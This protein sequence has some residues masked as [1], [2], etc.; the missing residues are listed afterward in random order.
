[1][2][3]AALAALVVV[4]TGCSLDLERLRR[5]S[6]ASTDASADA[7]PADSGTADAAPTDGSRPDSGCAVCTTRTRWN[8][9]LPGV[10]G[11]QVLAVHASDLDLDGA[12]DVLATL[13]DSTTELL[14]GT[15]PG[16]STP[17][18]FASTRV[19]AIPT[20][21]TPAIY[22]RDSDGDADVAVPDGTARVLLMT[23]ETEFTRWTLLPPS[24]A[25]LDFTASVAVPAELDL[26]GDLDTL[27]FG[28]DT[29]VQ[30]VSTPDGTTHDLARLTA[31]PIAAAA[32]SRSGGAAVITVAFA[33]VGGT[34]EI[35]RVIGAGFTSDG[36]LPGVAGATDLVFVD[37][38][39]DGDDELVIAD[40]VAR[41][42]WVFAPA[43]GTYGSATSI[44]IDDPPTTVTAGDVTNDGVVELVVG[45][46]DASTILIVDSVARTVVETIASV[47]GPNDVV[48]TDLE[49]DGLADLVVGG[50]DT[51]AARVTVLRAACDL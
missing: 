20:A 1:M 39:V 47:A 25:L 2:R 6:D 10:M 7:A 23:G 22:D 44:P 27:V 40:S 46:R 35:G 18:A 14:Y 45:S 26:D 34:V 28:G 17:G 12:V 5:G 43:G 4:V 9:E 24:L 37:L 48:V 29:L 8:R 51:V 42:L 32:T 33:T 11:T 13:R 50:G 30:W 38:D 3:A 41:V 19:V 36:A 31:E 15:L 49:R 16:C 21:R